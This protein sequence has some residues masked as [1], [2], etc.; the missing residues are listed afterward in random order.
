MA[1]QPWPLFQFIDPVHRQQESLYRGSVRR[2]VS[3]YTQDNTNTE[4]T[5]TIQ[6][7]MPWV[8]FEPT[9][10]ALERVKTVRAVDHGA[11]VIDFYA[12]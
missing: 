3:T 10:T 1:L 11:T 4:W 9:I 6:T 5:H 2:K 12:V 7:F 8:G